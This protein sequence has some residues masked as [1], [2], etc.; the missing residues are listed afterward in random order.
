MNGLQ[1]IREQFN[2][3]I[4][5]LARRMGISYQAVSQWERG[6]RQ[7]PIKR[8]DELSAIFG[9]PAQ[10]F[11]DIKESD[12][13]ELDFTIKFAKSNSEKAH[14]ASEYERLLESEKDTISKIKNAIDSKSNK[15]ESLNEAM[16]L[17]EREIKRLEKISIITSSQLCDIFDSILNV[18]IDQEKA[19]SNRLQLI[20]SMRK[21]ITAVLDDAEQTEQD[22]KWKETHKEEFDELY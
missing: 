14:L 10:Y 22:K 15:Q 8:L 5:A 9:I 3:S 1:Y 18:F 11:T 21:E 17:M 20:Q 6:F 19:G 16:N 12:I 13:D 4:A 2:M 7:I